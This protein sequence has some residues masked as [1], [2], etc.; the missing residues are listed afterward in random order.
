MNSHT[1]SARLKNFKSTVLVAALLIAFLGLCAVGVVPCT[2]QSS[3]EERELED[4]IPKH[5]PIKVKVKNLNKQNW[6]REVEVEVKNTGDKPIYYLGFNLQM[7]EVITETGNGVIVTFRYGRSEL[8]R[9]ESRP[10]PEDV[11]IQAGETYVMKVPEND[12]AGWEAARDNR[13][14]SEPKKFR[15]KFYL[16]HHGDGTGF[17][18]SGGLPVPNPNTTSSS[19]GGGARQASP[20]QR[21]TSGNELKPPPAPSFQFAPALLPV[22]FLPAKLFVERTAAAPTSNFASPQAGVCCPGRFGCFSGREV[23]QGHTCVTCGPAAW[24]ESTTCGSG[25]T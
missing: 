14:W 2:A 20:A 6:V 7:P 8:G 10:T 18:T 9:F 15:I 12:M 3:P 17:M 19:C 11:P 23:P 16:L 4:K 1:I 22:R 13:K 24:V 21:A 5:L 25:R